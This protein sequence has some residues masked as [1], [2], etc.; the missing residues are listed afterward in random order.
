MYIYKVLANV[1]Y[2]NM[3]S[4]RFC[5]MGILSMRNT[6][7]CIILFKIVLIASIMNF[8][9]Q[10]KMPTRVLYHNVTN[11]TISIYSKLNNIEVKQSISLS[12][13]ANGTT[14][15]IRKYSSEYFPLCPPEEHLVGILKIDLDLAEKSYFEMNNM[16]SKDMKTHG[17]TFLGNFEERTLGN[18]SD[19]VLVFEPAHCLPPHS[20]AFII[21]FRYREIHL[22]L[23]LGHLIPILQRQFLRYSIFVINQSGNGTFNKGRLMN[24]GFE[25]ASMVGKVNGKPFDCFIFHDVDLL[26]EYDT[27]LYRCPG[28]SAAIHMATT[29]DKFDY[30]PMCCGITVGGVLGMTEEQFR[31]VNGYSNEYWGWGGEDDDI[32]GRIRNKKYWL[33]RPD[34]THGRYTMLAHEKDRGNAD[35]GNRHATL[36]GAHE[37]W[38]TDGLKNLNTNVKSI[39]IY[40]QFTKI[41]VDVG[42]PS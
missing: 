29:I 5:N 35:N 4:R 7:M 28:G 34:A 30:H 20:V 33:S 17:N 37:R 42:K 8:M 12:L 6:V 41:Y 1:V 3:P 13:V 21:P 11:Y 39:H 23:L 26:A 14:G 36:K 18:I 19:F 27:L 32:N 24:T 22:R 31:N 25:I 15:G 16:T 40:P 38:D 9:F 2:I 10:N